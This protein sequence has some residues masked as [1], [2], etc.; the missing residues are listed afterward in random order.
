L[1]S[2]VA[3]RW[4]MSS[5][6]TDKRPLA[7]CRRKEAPSR[8]MALAWRIMLPRVSGY[9]KWFVSRKAARPAEDL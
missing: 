2:C 1:A 5:S 9:A 8:E 3:C 6:V 4:T 7:A